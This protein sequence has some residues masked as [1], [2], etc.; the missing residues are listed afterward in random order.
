MRIFGYLILSALLLTACQ[1][2]PQQGKK[3]TAKDLSAYNTN[4]S[5]AD[6]PV[7]GYYVPVYSE[8]Y[9][10]TDKIKIQLTV[11]LSI[12]N[13]S[14]SQK[15]YV[16]NVDYYNSHGRKLRSYLKKP[17]A[18]EPLQTVDF[19]VEERDT[20]GGPGPSFVVEAVSDASQPLI[21][22]VMIGTLNQQGISYLTEATLIK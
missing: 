21:Q 7:T 4:V 9:S 1:E 3:N 5:L 20:E 12:R 15:T 18:L 6:K 11:T 17:I 10:S 2:Q 8:I 22:A 16:R 19:V 14:T 13:T